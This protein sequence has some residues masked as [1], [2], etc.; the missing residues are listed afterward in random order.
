M[1]TDFADSVLATARRYPTPD[2]WEPGAACSDA[3]PA[4]DTALSDL[5]WD[6]LSSDPE[7]LP[8]AG[9]A[10]VGLGR[11]LAPLAAVDCLLGGALLLG[12]LARYATPGRTLITPRAGRLIEL[13]ADRL[14]PVGYIDALG[15]MRAHEPRRVREL[16]AEESELRMRAWVAAS[17]GYLAGV[18]AGALALVLEHAH[19]RIAFGAPLSALDPVQQM[20]ADAAVLSSGLELLAREEQ[21]GQNA[22]AFAADAARRA[23]QICQQVAGG[24]GF[25][26]E[27][28]LQRAYRRA[29]AAQSWIDSALGEWGGQ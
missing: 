20:L 27:F 15:V 9:P 8:F 4:L 22:L 7:L 19:S 17:T 6:E 5:G 10:A 29:G 24:I 26:L 12:D 18:A 2:R 25:T 3:N 16:P 11:E 21:I 1:A 23:L 14:E 28:P 13:T